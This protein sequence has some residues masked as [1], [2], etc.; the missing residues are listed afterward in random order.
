[1]VDHQVACLFLPCLCPV[2]VVILSLFVF[3]ASL[4][5]LFLVRCV[6][7]SAGLILFLMYPPAW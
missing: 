3:R 6:F 4:L 1:M 2:P 5:L 7:S